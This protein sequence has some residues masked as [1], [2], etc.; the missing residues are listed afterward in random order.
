MNNY[1]ILAGFPT[2]LVLLLTFLITTVPAP[3]IQLVP[4]FIDCI[5]VEFAPIKPK[6]PIET[7]PH[8]VTPGQIEIINEYDC[9]YFWN[10]WSFS[11]KIWLS[12]IVV[13]L[14]L[15]L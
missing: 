7:F 15:I 9:H 3:T 2:T 6:S 10:I 13:V 1:K 8:I 4:I 14:S 12:L 5:I 11:F